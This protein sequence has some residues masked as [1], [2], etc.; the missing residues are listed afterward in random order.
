MT[1]IADLKIGNQYEKKYVDMIDY[2]SYEISKGCFKPYDIKVVN[3]DITTTYEIKA[4]RMTAKTGNVVIEYACNGKPSGITSSEADYWVYFIV[5]TDEYI[6]I[7]TADLRQ[8][9]T[10]KKYTRSLK[11]GDGWRSQMYLFPKTVFQ[12][13]I[14]PTT[15]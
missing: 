13:Y 3:G 4:D 11:G 5:G 15:A 9:I 12:E 10:D 7:S 2:D 1:F 14:S 8:L 6:K